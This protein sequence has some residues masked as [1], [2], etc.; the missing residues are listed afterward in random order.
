MWRHWASCDVIG[1]HGMSFDIMST[2]CPNFA[3]CA[4]HSGAAGGLRTLL[5]KVIISAAVL[6]LEPPCTQ[7]AAGMKIPIP[8]A[9]IFFSKSGL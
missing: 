4:L 5:A 6:E 2:C 7:E 9:K 1:Y 3:L 8:M